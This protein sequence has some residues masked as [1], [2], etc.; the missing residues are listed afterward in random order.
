M[1]LKENATLN[2]II[3]LKTF[4]HNIFSF[5]KFMYLRESER[6]QGSEGEGDRILSKFCP[7]IAVSDVGL[8]L[9]ELLDHCLMRNQESN[10]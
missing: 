10:A 4:F 7:D 6:V 8:E 5:F 2:D 3:T 1:Y 9:P